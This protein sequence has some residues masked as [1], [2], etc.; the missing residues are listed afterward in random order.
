MLFAVCPESTYYLTLLDTKIK[1]DGK[2]KREIQPLDKKKLHQSGFF[3]K[4][5]LSLKNKK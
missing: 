3:E 2:K 1:G 4:T 5:I